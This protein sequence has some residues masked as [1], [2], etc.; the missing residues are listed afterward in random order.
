MRSLRARVQKK[1]CKEELTREVKVTNLESAERAIIPALQTSAFKE[2]LDV[3]MQM[4]RKNPNPNSRVFAQQRKTNIKTLSSLY[5]LDP[6]VDEDGILR[7]DGRLRRVSLSDDMKFPIIL[8]RNSHVTMLIVRYFHERRSHRRKTMTLN[9]VRSNGFWIISGSAVVSSIVSSCVK[10]NKLRGAVQ[11]QRM[12]DLP[13]DRLE[14]AP[15]LPT[16]PSTILVPLL[17][18]MAGRS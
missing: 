15:P 17:L 12:S 6:F 11:E 8:P 5:K 3:L 4:K 16:A 2:E 13:E 10:C 1:Q 9:E 14:T 7:V 18:K